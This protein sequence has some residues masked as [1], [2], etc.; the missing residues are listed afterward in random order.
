MRLLSISVASAVT[1]RNA[2]CSGVRFA[3]TTGLREFQLRARRRLA[4]RFLA[5]Q[6]RPEGDRRLGVERDVEL[7]QLLVAVEVAIDAVER[8]L[9]LGLVEVDAEDAF[10]GVEAK[11]IDALRSGAG[12]CAR[13]GA[14]APAA[15]KVEKNCVCP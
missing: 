13:A 14:A 8:H 5:R 6:I 15:S 2:I 9:L 12:C 4:G 1:G 10:G 3:G 7:A 11:A